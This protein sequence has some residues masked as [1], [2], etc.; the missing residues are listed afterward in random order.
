MRSI[1]LQLTRTLLAAFALLLGAA[2]VALV[3]MVREELEESFDAALRTS[4]LSVST[5]VEVEN[6]K[7]EFDFSDDFQ[8]G[9]GAERSRNYFEIRDGQ[10]GV[11]ARS[12]SLGQ[13][14]L[15]DRLSD[16][17]DRPK[18]FALT[19]PNGHAGRAISFVF[20]V[21]SGATPH[22]QPDAPHVKL[23]VATDTM[24]L[25]RTVHRV[26]WLVGGCGVVLFLAVGFAVPRVLRRGLR[27]LDQLGAEVSRI[28]AESL[29]TRFDSG[30]MPAE[31]KPIAERLNDV[32]ARLEASFE[33]ERRFSADLAHE[34]R[35]P[36]AEL[37]SIAEN[38]L[39]WPETR[40]PATDHETFAIATQMETL[41][42]RMLALTRG[43][44]GQLATEL[45]QIEVQT[46]IE[47]AWT[48]FGERAAKRG[49]K[50][51]FELEPAS[52]AADVV[53]FR[54]ILQNLFENAVTYAPASSAIRITGKA[55]GTHSGYV[56]RVGNPA[57]DLTPA[58][59]EWLFERFWRKEAA[60]GGSGEHVGLGLSLA[61][62]FAGAMGWR[63][64][65]ALD[66]K[67]WLVFRLERWEGK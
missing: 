18:A 34:L 41:V 59:V 63:L 13:S 55:T 27:P 5:L 49:L 39:K 46:A 17:P 2:L 14:D 21:K 62:V 57:P 54:S 12:P 24:E 36:L 50:V 40:D 44:R 30:K 3:L 28:D 35:T 26:V 58:D 65:A 51:E 1:R 43:E 7:L 25:E 23:I 29:K 37:R 48:P 47:S 31:L 6:G 45:V 53:L 56:V 4:A 19:L 8:R 22:A 38:A 15:P 67:G 16:R 66:D 60:R 11:L 64:N 20:G 10:G 32:L 33:R 61:R 42:T 52:V 9:F